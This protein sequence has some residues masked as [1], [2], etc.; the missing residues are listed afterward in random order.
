MANRS[1][2]ELLVADDAAFRFCEPPFNFNAP[3]VST[4]PVEV[5]GNHLLEGLR[6]RLGWISFADKRVLDFGCGVR[7]ARTIYNL[8][9]PFG[10]YAGVD[11]NRDAINWLQQNLRDSRFIF[12]HS[13]ARNAYYN[14]AGSD[15]LGVDALVKLGLPAF[16]AACMFSVITHQAPQEARQIFGQLRQV[17]SDRGQLYFTAFTDHSVSYYVEKQPEAPGHMS[18]YHPDHLIEL[19]EAAG[20][21]VSRAYEKSDLQQTA[22]VCDTA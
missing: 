1:Y 17:V 22:F 20:W 18:T 4:Y 7:F 8:N 15:L 19:V 11:V 12:A 5:T 16:D 21:R 9:I 2:Q 10:L 13:E 14:P 6:R 3:G